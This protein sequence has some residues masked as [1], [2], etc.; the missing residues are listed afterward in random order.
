MDRPGRA[1]H[2]NDEG[3]VV[4]IRSSSCAIVWGI[5]E[6][7]TAAA[8]PADAGGSAHGSSGRNGDFKLSVR[9][10]NSADVAKRI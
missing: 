8:E 6:F 5:H 10:A 2:K 1:S 4:G 7:A 3:Q 9:M